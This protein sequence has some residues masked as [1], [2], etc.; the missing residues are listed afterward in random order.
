MC[1]TQKESPMHAFRIHL[2]WPTIA[3]LAW[4][5]ATA[6]DPGTPGGAAAGWA[7]LRGVRDAIEADVEAGRL[8]EIHAKSERLVPLANAL[9][10]GSKDLAPE[11]RARVESAVRQ[12]P[13]VAGALHEAADS[14]NAEATRRQLERLD[15]LLE[16][17]R[18]QYPAGALPSSAPATQGDHA[19]HEHASGH[20]HAMHGHARGTSAAPGHAHAERPL[21]AVEAEAV[22]TLLV[23]A[24]EFSFEPRRLELR[25]G[26]AT[27]IELRNEGGLEHALVVKTA[28]GAGDWIHLHAAAHGSDAGTFRLDRPGTYPL[29]CTVPGHTEAGM[30][31][32]L[33]V[34]AR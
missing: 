3:V 33:V 22:A 12:L 9:L 14:G 6:A 11:K 29:L 31:G 21:A 27:R 32:T 34:L 30:V 5:A 19:M 28:D 7:E 24:G 16:L 15:G 17:I 23:R 13:R 8:G 20:D 18:A 1:A 25:A 10:E 4:S 26:E 2:L